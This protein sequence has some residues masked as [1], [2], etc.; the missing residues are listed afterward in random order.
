MTTN[1]PRMVSVV[2]FGID[3]TTWK[4]ILLGTEK[5]FNISQKHQCYLSTPTYRVITH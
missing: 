4:S 2:V 1:E 3:V 5:Y